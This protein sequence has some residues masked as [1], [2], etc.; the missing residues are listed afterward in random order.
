MRNGKLWALARRPAS[1]PTSSRSFDAAL[2]SGEQ[3]E[4]LPLAFPVGHHFQLKNFPSS[5]TNR[6][7]EFLFS[8]TGEV[9]SRYPPVSH[10]AALHAMGHC[11]GKQ[12]AWTD[13]AAQVGEDTTRLRLW[14]MHQRGGSPE[15]IERHLL[16]RELAEI[17]ANQGQRRVAT[18]SNREQRIRP[19]QAHHAIATL[20]EIGCILPS[21]TT[22]IQQ[23]RTGGETLEPFDQQW[24]SS[25]PSPAP[26]GDTLLSRPFVCGDRLQD[27]L[28]CAIVSQSKRSH[29]C[30]A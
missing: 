25:M 26:S 1:K 5:S 8:P 29:S 20:S 24:S 4:P 13:K 27:Q 23:P 3:D 18:S 19:V 11:R 22:E 30:R 21:S 12:T 6:P 16:K 7:S 28:S 10:Y 9:A 17:G 2:F 15:T 14:N